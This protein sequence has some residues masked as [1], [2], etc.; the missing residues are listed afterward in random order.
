MVASGHGKQRTRAVN[1]KR[2]YSY[3]GPMHLWEKKDAVTR[4]ESL[5]WGGFEVSL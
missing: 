2:D 3:V 4:G 1:S 5:S